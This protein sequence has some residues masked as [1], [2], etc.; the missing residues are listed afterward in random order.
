M[1]GEIHPTAIV[2]PG[3]VLGEGCTVG[4]YS[5]IGPNVVLGQRNR[6]G[7]HVVIEG[8]TL[9]GDD[10]QIFQFASVGAAP[11]DLKY[12]GEPTVLQIGHRNVIREFVTLQ[13]G[14]VTGNKA[15]RIGDQ[16]LFMANCHVGHDGVVGSGNVFANSAALAGHVTVGNYATIGGLC[17]IHQFVSL[18]DQCI[19]GAGSMVTR[20]IPP[21]SMA[22]GDR[23]G[24][25]GL[26]RI[27]LE[28]RGASAEDI[29]RLRRLFRE[30]F[31]GE[32]T[33]NA[34]LERLQREHAGFE[35]AERFLTFIVSSKRGITMPRRTRGGA[36]ESA[37]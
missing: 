34:R 7:P 3:A 17:G 4:P 27:G 1:S 15:T 37:E 16:N 35:L 26:N 23:A 12:R 30:L 20:D 31:R 13:P 14:T 22:Q 8:H 21:F 2:H 10:N 28:R 36:A 19:L 11:Q 5:I 32:G 29:R 24:L 9:V 25:V 33:M 6:V 18:G